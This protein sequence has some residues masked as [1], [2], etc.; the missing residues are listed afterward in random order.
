MSKTVL[1][2]HGAWM[3]PACWDNFK[4]RYEARG[5]DCI[6]PAWPYDDRA[7]A[8]L[9]ASPNPELANLGI[10]EIVDH[11]ARIIEALPEPP[12]LVG[13][14]FGGLFV[15]LLLDRGLGR[16]GVAIDP[17]PPRGVLPGLSALRAALSVLLTWR[18]W[19]KIITMSFADFQWGFAHNQPEAEQRAAYDAHV[20]PT[21]GRIYF[22]AALGIETAVRFRNPSR[23]PLLLIAGT[24]D[25]T[26]QASMVRATYRKHSRSSA[27]TSFQ[28]FEGR[29]HFL[30]GAPGWEEIA[31]H[32]I[33]WA[34]AQVGGL[35][36]RS[37]SKPVGLR[38][39]EPAH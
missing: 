33:T 18:G 15:Q 19:R 27:T 38:L 34:E 3:T 7:V 13:H 37:A 20:V 12:I 4:K 17:G 14:S 8:E 21:P 23:A 6:A 31:D 26:V 22:Q 2:I 9:R 1:F 30:I 5:Y 16:A 35:A 10:R 28:A 24:D 39:A 36:P 29:T 11:Y 25:R 32:A